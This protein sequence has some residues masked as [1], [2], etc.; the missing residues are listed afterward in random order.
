MRRCFE[1]ARKG[2][3]LTNTNPL[4]GCVIVHND[5]IVGEGYHHEFGGPHAEVNAF[6]S[7]KDSSIF[8]EATMYCNLEPC[9]HHGKT[10]PCSMLIVQKGIRRVVIS[11]LDPFPSVNGKGVKQMEDAG[12]QV[13]SDC[14]AEEGYYLN[15]RFFIYQKKRRPYVVLKWAQTIDGFIDLEREPGD[16]VGTNWITGEVCRTLVHKWRSEEAAILVGTNTVMSD[17]PRLNVRRW[18]GDNPVRI[19][20]DRKGRL[21]GSSNILD[22]KQDTIVFAGIPGQYSGKTRSIQV[23]P[24]YE[25]EDLLEELFDQQIISIL[26]EGGAQLLESFLK[27][28]LWDEARV[29]TGKMSFSQGVNAPELHKTPDETL[30]FNDTKL[31]WYNNRD[32]LF[33]N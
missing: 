26:V 6:R 21:S 19:T 22:G 24:S 17:N 13:E 10:P 3:G 18:S 31:K 16:P 25:L 30:V 33:Y 1:L 9:A 23:D 20:L 28:G 32:D 7:V 27:S 5:R 4:V 11:N 29:F 2:L 12:I 15:R 8:P 14:L